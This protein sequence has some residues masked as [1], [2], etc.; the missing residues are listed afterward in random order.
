MRRMVTNAE[1]EK[2][3]GTKLYKHNVTFHMGWSGDYGPVEAEF[4][5]TDGESLAGKSSDI[6]FLSGTLS[7]NY[8][9]HPIIYISNYNIVFYSMDNYEISGDAEIENGKFLTDT[10]EAL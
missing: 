4:V 6:E 2:L 9:Y 10:V 1:I 8:N 5:T 7:Y 3:G